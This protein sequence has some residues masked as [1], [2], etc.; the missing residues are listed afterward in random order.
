[1]ELSGNGE[2]V[3]YSSIQNATKNFHN[4]ISDNDDNNNNYNN[5]NYNN[6]NYNIIKYYY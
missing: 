1:M 3:A 2:F 5:Y 4:K 6:Y